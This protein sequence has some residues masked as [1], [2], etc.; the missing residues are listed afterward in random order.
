MKALTIASLTALAF[1]S[2]ACSEPAPTA[3]TDAAGVITAEMTPASAP[4]DDGFNL[5]IPGEA[6]ATAS[7]DDGFNLPIREF[8]SNASSDGFNLPDSLPTNSG[9]NS[10]PEIDTTIFDE[11]TPAEAPDEDAIIRLD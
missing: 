9:L 8:G 2:A 4:A 11:A 7:S 6:P 1:A 3:K 10:V 5:R